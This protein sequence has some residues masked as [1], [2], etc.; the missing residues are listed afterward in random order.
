MSRLS[1]RAGSRNVRLGRETAKAD[2]EMP[3]TAS[4]RQDLR[5]LT[6]LMPY[7]TGHKWMLAAA[8]ISMLLAA[9]ATL[10]VP[11]G[12]RPMIDRGFSA[13]NAATIDRY[14]LIM[15]GIGV[16]LALASA[17]RFFFVNWL[18]ERLVADLR[19]DVFSHLTGLSP[20]FYETT[21]S[22]E[23]MSRLTADTTQ[24]KA[25][26]ATSASQ[27]VRNIIMVLGA[28]TMMM[29]S[30]PKLSA[31]VVLAIP[32]IVLP[33]IAYGRA[34]R[35]L[36]RRAQDRLAEAS[37]FAA[38]NLSAVQTLQAF[39]HEKAVKS[40]F[41]AAVERAFQAARDRMVARTGLTALA[42]ALTFAS[43][44]GILWYGAHEVLDGRMTAGTLGQFVLYALFA[45]GA[46]GGLVEVWGE[47][48]QT[49]G[50][51]ERL[52]ELLG[53]RPLIRSPGVPESLPQEVRGAVAFE[54]IDF[55][56]PARLEAPTLADVSFVT[57]P[58]ET[59]AIVGPSGAGKSTIFA[60]LLRFYDPGSGRITLDGI[61]ISR[62]RLEDLRNQIALVPQDVAMFADTV[63]ENISYGAPDA[64]RTE[65]KDAARAAQ[66]LDF[67]EA[68][69]DGFDT[70]LGERGVLL[71]GGQRQRIAIARAI[72]R[73][74]PI[75]LLDEATSA[76]DSE[77]EARVQKALE[78]VMSGRTTLVIAHRLSTVKAAD[79]I[80]VLEEG[81][82]EEQG[83]HDELVAKDGT[84]ARLARLQFQTPE[85]AL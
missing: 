78:T 11:L 39:T 13:E 41:I 59:L 43:I 23:V 16:V 32:F 9:L 12:V 83:R 45:A 57:E 81:R 74:A 25:A 30:S 64:S 6:M 14:F 29:V 15:M 27:T 77:S 54:Q 26:L 21:H 35:S 82:I 28:V 18:G 7:L 2:G 1:Q 44:I 70:K 58:G 79:R 75:L 69:P 20:A 19:S 10:A 61:P 68:L 50:A 51:A 22:G 52:A 71:S 56:Y 62:L 63:A 42:I 53:T 24:I 49:A 84:Y 85:A 31:L 60:L 40:R 66:A 5:P 34:V 80:L 73:D 72:L 38:E 65:I 3:E 8:G 33:I 55:A 48:Q 4:K 46:M 37:A 47:V 36:S 17:A 76:L 67:I